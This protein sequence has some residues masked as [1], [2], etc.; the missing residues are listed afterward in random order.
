MTSEAQMAQIKVAIIDMQPITPAIGGGRQRLLG[1]YHALGSG[2]HAT[3]VGSYD[4]PGES[5]RDHALTPGLREI[6]VPLSDEHH[7]AASASA[8][9]MAGRVVIDLEFDRQVHLS[10]EFLKVA[11]AHISDADIVVFSHPWA[12]PALRDSLRPEQL[13]VYD[14]QNVESVLRTSLHD[15]LPQAEPLLEHVAEIECQLVTEADLTLTC[16]HDDRD[17]FARLFEADWARLRVV[18]NG[19]F[20]FDQ[21]VHTDQ[22]R[23]ALKG[24]LG[25]ERDCVVFLGSNYAPNNAAAAFIVDTLAPSLPETTFVLLGGCCETLGSIPSNVR[26]LGVVDEQVKSRWIRAADVALNPLAS[27]SGTSIKMFDFM[28]AG[29]PVLTTEVGARGIVVTGE[30]PFEMASLAEFPDALRAMLSDIHVRRV[31]GSRGRKTVES[32]YAW[33]RISPGLGTLLRKRFQEKSRAPLDFSVIIPSYERHA[34]LD[35]LM[36][37]LAAQTRRGFEVIVIDQSQQPWARAG[38]QFEFPLTYIH[39]DVRGAVKARNLGGTLASGH[40]IAFTDDDCEPQPDWLEQGL[41]MLADADVVGV[42]G[43]IRSDHMDDPEWRPVTN[44]GFEGIGFMTANLMVRNDCFQALNGFDM[45][46]DEP[47]FREDTDFG[48]RLQSLGKVPYAESVVVYHPA[49]KR[50][51]ARESQVERNRFF[52]KDALLMAKHP[53]RFKALFFAEQHYRL[54]TGYWENLERGIAKYRTGTPEW[55]VL[56]KH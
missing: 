8:R 18:P 48:W 50:E 14:S 1:L 41:A 40:V 35:I 34:L 4:W 49:H 47:H 12:Y 33:E 46:F 44:I 3:Y 56:A 5:L 39:T 54:T 19:I 17:T 42:E 53:E 37:Q 7:A 9:G 29:T 21:Q 20:A 6:C 25:I 22:E 24:E 43:L 32:F 11:R 45:A 31:L 28:A 26:A 38:E 23:Q 36:G 30:L 2:I 16:S 15:D 10:P 52:E 27:G 51:L 55:L 13:V